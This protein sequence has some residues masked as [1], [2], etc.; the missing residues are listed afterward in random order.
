M[1]MPTS[2]FVRYTAGAAILTIALAGTA[3]CSSSASS[4]PSASS[5]A[6]VVINGHNAQDMAFLTDMIAHHQQAI[7]MAQMV[8]SHTNNAKVT[9]LAAQ[10]EA[11]QGPEIAKMQTWLDEWNEG[12]PSASA[13]SESAAS[14]HG[15]SGMDH[16]AA[17]SSSSS[18]MPGMMTDKQMAD[19]ESKNGAAFD[20]MWLTMMIDHH[21]GAITMAQQELAMGENAQVKA[22]AQAIID[23]QTTEIATMKAML[24]Q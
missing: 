12:Q 14:G 2:R 9:A 19:L 6:G 18:P 5:S 16:G 8:P 4:S 13:G 23:G 24:A 11:A 22:V 7:D 1:S 20:K 10:I 17:P 3:A 15:M 21:Q